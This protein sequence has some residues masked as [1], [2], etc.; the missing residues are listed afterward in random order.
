MSKPK[1]ARTTPRSSG[2]K[3]Y[4]K[5]EFL[6]HK[7]N[8]VYKHQQKYHVYVGLTEVLVTE[9]KQIALVRAAQASEA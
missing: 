5:E 8:S 6:A 4:G 3:V 9:D 7:G 1:V 2:S